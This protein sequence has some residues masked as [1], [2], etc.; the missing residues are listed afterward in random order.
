VVAVVERHRLRLP[1]EGAPSGVAVGYVLG[2]GPEVAGGG[3]LALGIE[4]MEGFAE[5]AGYV[6]GDVFV[7]DEPG[8]RMGWGSLVD[9]VRRTRPIA[10]LTPDVDGLR[11]VGRELRLAR[12]RL[13]HVTSA[14]LVT[15]GLAPYVAPEVS[16]RWDDVLRGGGVGGEWSARMPTPARRRDADA[17]SRFRRTRLGWGRRLSWGR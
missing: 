16:I 10:V 8:H 6:L 7:D 12:D 9:A 14:P 2:P 15:A 17:V 5:R 13:R 4:V 3:L 1:S 11:L